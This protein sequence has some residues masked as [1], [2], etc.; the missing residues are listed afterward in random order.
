MLEGD[1]NYLDGRRRGSDGVIILE[2]R[3]GGGGRS[4]IRASRVSATIE[5]N[6]RIA[7]GFFTERFGSKR[8]NVTSF[9]GKFA[10]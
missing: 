3:D 7:V 6:F 9:V 2:G 4:L 1:D 10:R 5:C 8:A